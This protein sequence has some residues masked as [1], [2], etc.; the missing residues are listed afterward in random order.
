M[1][2]YLI[3]NPEKMSECQIINPEKMSEYP[4]AMN[5]RLF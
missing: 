2:E 1:S 3:I 5:A 4:L